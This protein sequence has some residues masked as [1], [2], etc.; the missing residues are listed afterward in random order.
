ML[1]VSIPR[2]GP[3]H[4]RGPSHFL[5]ASPLPNLRA[6]LAPDFLMC[7]GGKPV[8]EGARDKLSMFCQVGNRLR[9]ARRG[10]LW[11]ASLS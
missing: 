7:R 5:L 9:K 11:G 4:A 3:F 6:G 1:S 2:L 10:L 8:V